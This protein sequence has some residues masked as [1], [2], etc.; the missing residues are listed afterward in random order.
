M[1]IGPDFG[2]LCGLMMGSK[3]LPHNA[4]TVGLCGERRCIIVVPT[5]MPQ[6]SG[7]AGD[8]QVGFLGVGQARVRCVLVVDAD[9]A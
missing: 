4:V 9:L 2:D 7:L 5:Q 3:V 1:G 6:F 8:N